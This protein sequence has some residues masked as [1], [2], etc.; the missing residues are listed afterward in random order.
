MTAGTQTD[1]ARDGDSRFSALLSNSAAVRAVASSVESTL[2]PKGLNVMLVDGAGDVTVTND[3]S[4]ILTQIDAA[5]PAARILIRAARSQDEAVG[6]GTT[7]TAVLA[8]ALIVEGVAQAVR[9]VPISMLVDG[10]RLGV[11]AAIQFI[12]MN[13]FTVAGLD[14][15]NLEKAVRIAAR[16]EEKISNAV[17]Q[18]ARIVGVD[19]L[20]DSNC[21]LRET[22]SVVAGL[23]TEAF[24]GILITKDR[25]NRQM[26]MRLKNAKV[27]VVDDALEPDP[28]DS[29][30]LSTERGFSAYLQ[31]V[32]RFKVAINRLA[33][34]GVGLVVIEK[35]I[36]DYAE[37]KL[38]TAG[39]LVIRRLGAND[40]HRIA[41]HTG[42]SM[43]KRSAIMDEQALPGLFGQ[44]ESVECDETRSVTFIRGGSGHSAATIMIGAGTSEVA[45]EVKRI[46]EDACGALQTALTTGLV[47]GGGAIELAASLEVRKLRASTS[48]MSAYGIDCVEAALKRPLAQIVANSGYNPLDKV[49][50]AASALEKSGSVNMAI[51]C[52]TGEIADMAEMGVLDP[53]GIKIQALKT[54]GEVAEAILR[55]NTIVRRKTGEPQHEG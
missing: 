47:A 12:R 5:H 53:A 43:V 51:D 31:N 1:S 19:M 42:A 36:H 23:D 38:T 54:A 40:L 27:L 48:G 39:C 32:E 18:A 2:G 28:I 7:T 10:I 21:H 22:L 11:D 55:I 8:S 50:L 9:G 37:E 52:D 29:E 41:S 3:G 20:A 17:M 30:A 33:A 44:V 46:A 16:G 13:A 15:P 34:S 6:D 49:E 4:T 24:S 26:P 25:L 45:Q 14:D 35:G